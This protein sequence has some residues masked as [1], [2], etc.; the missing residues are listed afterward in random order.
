MYRIRCDS[1]IFASTIRLVW[2]SLDVLD[3]AMS[4]SWN[5]SWNVF[6]RICSW[7]SF[8]ISLC[9]PIESDFHSSARFPIV[10]RNLFVFLQ[11]ILKLI[12]S[13]SCALFHTD[14]WQS[15]TGHRMFKRVSGPISSTRFCIDLSCWDTLQDVLHGCCIVL[16]FKL[17]CPCSFF[18]LHPSSV[19]DYVMSLSLLSL[20][21]ISMTYIHTTD[22]TVWQLLFDLSYCLING[23]YR[24]LNQIC[25]DLNWRRFRL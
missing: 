15:S 5:V 20:W 16:S 8:M 18:L 12:F 6:D 13:R 24:R 2:H 9:P 19:H 17:N 11:M 22:V 3:S 1:S 7:S 4:A 10:A 14:H 25:A 21:K 23:W